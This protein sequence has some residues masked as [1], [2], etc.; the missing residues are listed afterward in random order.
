MYKRK[1]FTF[2]TTA[3]LIVT[4]II[5]TFPH[6]PSKFDENKIEESEEYY[7]TEVYIPSTYYF[8][9]FSTL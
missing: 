4:T 7:R 3:I 8:T 6:L 9:N 2:F 1:S 5:Y